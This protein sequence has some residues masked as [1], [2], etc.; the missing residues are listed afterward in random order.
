MDTV[1]V[2]K[3]L[4]IL[5]GLFSFAVYHTNTGRGPDCDIYMRVAHR[6]VTAGHLN[7][8]PQ[9]LA[10][11]TPWQITRSN[12][13]PIH[14]N[15]GG[16]LF[17][18]PAS[19]AAFA[20]L[21]VASWLPGL[22]QRL[23]DLNYHAMLWVGSTAY[24]LALL[25]CLLMFRVG[26]CYGSTQAIVAALLACFYGGPLLIYTAG[27]PCQMTLPGAFLA[28]L[29]L[30]L[31]HYTDLQQGR[32]WLLLGAVWGLGVMVRA[33][34]VAWGLLLL[35]GGMAQP[36]PGGG[37]WR[38]LLLRLGLAGGGGLL[39]V[40][41]A[42]MVRQVVFGA[43]GST[44]GIQFDLEILKQAS[45]MLVGT[46]NGLFTFWPVLLLALLGYAFRVRRNPALFHV[47]AVILVV[48]AVICGSTNF[49]SGEMGASFGQRRFLVVLPC[50]ILFLARLF[51]LG[52]A[53]FRGLA[54][55]CAVGALWSMALYSVY[56]EGWRFVDGRS[57]FLMPNHYP[58]LLS[59]L[60]NCATMLPAKMVALVLLPKHADMAWLLPLAAIAGTGGWLAGRAVRRRV[61]EW[62]LATLLIVG[63]A[64]IL[65]LAGARERGEAAFA[66][67]AKANPEARFVVRN[68]EIDNEI[69]GSLVDVVSFFMEIGQGQTAQDFVDKGT[70]FLEV[71]APDRLDSFRHMVEALALRHS[72]GWY[73]LVPEQS[74]EGLLA[75]YRQALIYRETGA[76]IPD[77]SG[78]I[79]Y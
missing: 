46:R 53:Y 12:H 40:V 43:P 29:L 4:L 8:L 71:E 9:E 45:L 2:R 21:H 41:P 59:A 30:Y 50:F 39:F 28:A 79:L 51:D 5:V 73:R 77:Y 56:G 72:L 25:F 37:R 15:V 66:A 24:G 65:L 13:A 10:T 70:R 64:T 27:F 23:Y 44:Y 32:S 68:Y 74:H 55:L 57:G 11:E 22:P 78:Q 34:F 19:A 48:V 61:T 49:W 16:V 76:E 62:C 38:Q 3:L 63:L 33:E 69:I 58:V 17:F 36:H 7:I 54:L 1:K 26:R 31:Y 6:L 67:I 60:A 42:A 35:Y 14:Q 52:R 75:W 20:S 47:L 18:L